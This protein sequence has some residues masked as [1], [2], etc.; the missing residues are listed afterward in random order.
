[1]KGSVGGPTRGGGAPRTWRD[2]FETDVDLGLDLDLRPGYRRDGPKPPVRSIPRRRR[3]PTPN[4]LVPAWLSGRLMR[5]LLYAGVIVVLAAA[6]FR[7]PYDLGARLQSA[8]AAA[9]TRDVNLEQAALAVREAVD[10]GRARLAGIVG[11][12]DAA[13]PAAGGGTTGEPARWLWPVAGTAV[14]G[15][16]WIQGDQGAVLHEGLDIAADPGSPVVAAA[17]GTVTRVWSE[18]ATGGL[19]VEIDHGGGWTTRYLHLQEAYIAAGD[20]VLPG[21]VIATSGASGHGDR[22]AL[23]F[24]IRRDGSAVDP[25]PKLRRDEGSS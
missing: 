20:R 10:R 17:A 15:Y 18:P 11:D 12:G 19:A 22:P 7:L 14:A 13:L 4:V 5:Q 16:G 24:E 2:D 1:M 6:A 3:S 21:N 23:H 25:E 9:L 8:A